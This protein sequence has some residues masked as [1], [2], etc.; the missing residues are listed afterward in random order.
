M[1]VHIVTS[2]MTYQAIKSRGENGLCVAKYSGERSPDVYK[3]ED[4]V[5]WDILNPFFDEDV[6]KFKTNLKKYLF[7]VL[8][9]EKPMP[10]YLA[11]NENVKNYVLMFSD[12]NEILSIKYKL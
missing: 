7:D 1:Y 8:M 11:Y 10:C 5:V 2:G 9:I 12:D 3:I 6:L 4:C